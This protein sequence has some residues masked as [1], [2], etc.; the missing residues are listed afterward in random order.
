MFMTESVNAQHKHN[1][2]L[3]S[4]GVECSDVFSALAA[5]GSEVSPSGPFPLVTVSDTSWKI[6]LCSVSLT[7]CHVNYVTCL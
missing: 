1:L 6:I 2:H 5:G 7:L 3:V 4:Y